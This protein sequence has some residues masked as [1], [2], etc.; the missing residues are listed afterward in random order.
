[1]GED[2]ECKK[3]LFDVLCEYILKCDSHKD[4]P[5]ILKS[6]TAILCRDWS[7]M[8]SITLKQKF[9]LKCIAACCSRI[10][11][12]HTASSDTLQWILTNYDIVMELGRTYN[13]YCH[14]NRLTNKNGHLTST[15]KQQLHTEL[16]SNSIQDVKR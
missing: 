11:P 7:W 8:Q 2:S 16:F 10:R 15:G 9:C 5:H 12:P 14:Q 6:A 13:S 1:M 4:L 3:L